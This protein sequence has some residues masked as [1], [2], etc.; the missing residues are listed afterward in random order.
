MNKQFSIPSLAFLALILL[1]QFSCSDDTD[2]TKN[3]PS[4]AV[5]E[6]EF[7][8]NAAFEDLDFLTLDVLQ[9]SGLGARTQ[10]SADLCANATVTHNENTRKITVDFGTGCTSPNGVIR[11]GKILLSYTGSNFLFPGTSI[12]TTFEGYEVNGL[13]I[14]GI[15]TITNAGINLLTSRVTLNV[16]IENG[17]I[18]WPDNSKVTYNSTQV[19][20][21]TLGSAGYDV[22]VTGTAS[23]KSRGGV[24]YTAAV[25]EP[26][27]IKEVCA[28]TGVFIPSSGVLAFTYQN[29]TVT[30]NYGIGTC[31]KVVEITY[32][33]GS[34]EITLD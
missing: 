22:S 9:R 3:E 13:K 30:A 14:Q 4:L 26:L 8:I 25:I 33:G 28:R 27:I 5:V 31:D 11:K 34:K 19:R 17:L 12:V 2:P 10:A 23:G 18:T 20:Q 6:D 1:A 24:D 16:K 7:K 32:P 21:A 15:R 29:F